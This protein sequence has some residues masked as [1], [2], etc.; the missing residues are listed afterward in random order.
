MD[1]FRPSE[2]LLSPASGALDTVAARYA[3][4]LIA[5]GE[6][7]RREGLLRTPMRAAKAMTD[8]TRG[9][10]DDLASLVNGARFA[11]DNREMV[12]V[13]DITFY[14]LCEHH[15]LPFFGRVHVAYL[16]AGTVIGLSKIPRIVDMFARR[17]QIQESMTRQIAESIESATGADG[18]GVVV[19]GQHMCMMMRGVEKQ[20]AS[21]TTS[22]MLGRFQ[23]EAGSRGRF[24]EL[25]R[26]PAVGFG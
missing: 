1:D 22:A 21:M 20:G 25:L 4:I 23:D 12:V 10:R 7:P 6:D 3:D 16:P 8:L 9:Y 11:S 24:L 17:L 2:R 13:R 19:E 5:L 26:V 15:L 14:S 18:V